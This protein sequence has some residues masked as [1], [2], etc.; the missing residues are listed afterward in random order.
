MRRNRSQIFKHLFRLFT[1]AFI[2]NNNEIN[3]LLLIQLKYRMVN[4]I[5][6]SSQKYLLLNLV[7]EITVQHQNE[8]DSQF[9]E[10]HKYWVDSDFYHVW[11]FEEYIPTDF[12]LNDNKTNQ[13]LRVPK[14]R[15]FACGVENI[16]VAIFYEGRTDITNWNGNNHERI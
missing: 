3:A 8:I 15:T 4:I 13:F 6:I 2:V 9:L 1:T 5:Y 11:G 7:L 14:E 16:I 10:C 12:L